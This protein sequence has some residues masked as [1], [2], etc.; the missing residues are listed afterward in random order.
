MLETL[1]SMVVPSH[2]LMTI[3]S[4]TN[5]PWY[6]PD[7]DPSVRQ[8]PELA[9]K[10]CCVHVLGEDSEDGARLLAERFE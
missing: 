7:L 4:S 5:A 8:I 2:R 1:I 10:K 3:G 9:A 6:L